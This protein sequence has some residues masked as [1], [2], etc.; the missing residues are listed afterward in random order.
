MKNKARYLVG[1]AAALS[2]LTACG[3]GATET[4]TAT[5]RTSQSPASVTSFTGQ[6]NVKGANPDCTKVACW[7]PTQFEPRLVERE[8]VS[9]EEVPASDPG[10][11]QQGWPMDGDEVI[12][13]CIAQGNAA[14][15]SKTGPYLNPAGQLQYDWYGIRV[16][17]G[18]LSSKAKSDPRLHQTGQDFR[19]YVAIS[20]IQGGE[21]KRLPACF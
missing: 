17:A 11:P 15:G 16:P 18:K 8:S 20:W 1:V 2:L 6:V 13:E 10:G 5:P 4:T 14:S 12:V 21:G 7:L 3:S 19:G 9:L